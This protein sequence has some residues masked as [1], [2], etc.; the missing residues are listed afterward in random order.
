MPL[1]ETKYGKLYY[2]IKGRGKKTIMLLHG[3]ALSSRCFYKQIPLLSKKYKLIIV[4][5]Q[6]HGKL[7]REKVLKRPF[8]SYYKNIS[9]LIEKLNLKD[10]ILIGHSGGGGLAI[11]LALTFP[12]GIKALVL[13]NTSYKLMDNLARKFFWDII[14]KLSLNYNGKL[15]QKVS[16]FL[17]NIFRLVNKKIKIDKELKLLIEEANNIPKQLVYY[18]IRDLEKYNLKDELKKIKVPTLIIGGKRDFITPSEMSVE[19]KEKIPNSELILFD[20][21]HLLLV[22]KNKEV[23]TEIIKFLEK[24]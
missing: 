20:G 13:V 21:G 2:E 15:R 1:I 3:V 23:N 12:K 14:S 18:E 9:F 16:N 6:G 22:E 7:Q 10:L 17:E 19:L 8:W 5:A 4:D 24:L 11:K